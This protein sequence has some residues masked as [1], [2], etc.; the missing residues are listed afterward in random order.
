MGRVVPRAE[1]TEPRTRALRPAPRP[2]TS[3]LSIAAE[4]PRRLR[5]PRLG[6]QATAA[7]AGWPVSETAGNDVSSS[8]VVCVRACASMCM[9]AR[10]RARACVFSVFVLLSLGNWSGILPFFLVFDWVVLQG[11]ED[12]QAWT[13]PY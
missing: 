6:T 1:R 10:V 7:A 4:P 8:R 9:R 13:R 11:S 3:R 5:R 12:H 2:W